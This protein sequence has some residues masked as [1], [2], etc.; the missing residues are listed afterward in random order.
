MFK[1]FALSVLVA[2]GLVFV[3][4]PV[5]F[6]DSPAPG[7]EV[8]GRFGPTDLPPGG[9]GILFL[10]VYNLGGAQGSEGPRVG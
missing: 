6:G 9:T 5:V 2:C 7:Y 4:V 1:R 8:I 10:Y 3:F